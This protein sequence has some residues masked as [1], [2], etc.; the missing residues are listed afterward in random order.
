MS[1]KT[2]SL[3]IVYPPNNLTLTSIAFS[4]ML[5]ECV[6]P[7]ENTILCQE[8]FVLLLLVK[9]RNVK[10]MTSIINAL[11]AIILKDTF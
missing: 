11:V 10:D 8:E 5:P 3:L 7:A 6:F 1:S 4:R 9:I 2:V